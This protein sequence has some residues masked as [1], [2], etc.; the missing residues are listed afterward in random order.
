MSIKIIIEEYL[1]SVS[2]LHLQ[3]E[4]D[5]TL[6]HGKPFDYANRAFVEHNHLYHMHQM[7]P[8]EFN[9]DG[10]YHHCDFVK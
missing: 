9:I 7:M 1:H 8:D 4:F 5:P 10:N 6:I 2:N 3:V